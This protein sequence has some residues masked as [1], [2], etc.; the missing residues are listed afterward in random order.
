MSLPN[1]EELRKLFETDP[2]AFEAKRLE[3]IESHISSQPSESQ[4]ALRATQ[5]AVNKK[6]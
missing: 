1:H 6:L 5:E 2:E 3:L 4:D